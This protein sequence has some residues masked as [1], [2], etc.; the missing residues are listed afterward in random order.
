MRRLPIL[1]LALLAAACGAKQETLQGYAEADYVY[2]SPQDPGLIRTLSV[3]EGDEVASGAALFT[4]NPERARA[5]YEAAQAMSQADSARALA[6]AV[7]AARA[8][9]RLADLTLARTR[10][11][12]EQNFIS[13]ARLDQDRAAADAAHA[14][15]RRVQTEQSNASRENRAQDA[16]AALARTQLTD[17]AIAAPVAARVERIYRRPGEYVT[18]GAPVLALLPPANMKLRFFVPQALLSRFA[19]GREIDVSC[20]GCPEG[21]KARVSFVATEPQFTPPV[22]YSTEERGK[23]VFLVEARPA[24][25]A[26]LRPGQ[27]LDIRVPQ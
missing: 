2:V 20:D 9:A 1:A 22:I 11:L 13:R 8:E 17:R 15:L 4:L 18:P 19:P 24:A 26:A 27:P 6:Q 7:V 14:E 5:N 23:L 12:Y 25:P 16:Q 10:S 3:R 21:L